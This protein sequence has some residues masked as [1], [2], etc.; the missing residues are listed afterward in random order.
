[1]A[2]DEVIDVPVHSAEAHAGRIALV[3]GADARRMIAAEAGTRNR[4]GGVVL[5]AQERKQ[6]LGRH[7][8]TQCQH[9][10]LQRCD[11]RAEHELHLPS[12][13]YERNREFRLFKFPDGEDPQVR[14]LG[15]GDSFHQLIFDGVMSQLCIG[16]EIHFFQDACPISAD[17]LDAER[18]LFGDLGG[19]PPRTDQAKNLVF[20]VG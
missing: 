13:G 9:N 8:N 18:E 5:R 19:S 14:S 1:M 15:A 12:Q 20:T 16:V 7:R 11:R 2:H 10:F 17:G 3:E 6:R 4:Q